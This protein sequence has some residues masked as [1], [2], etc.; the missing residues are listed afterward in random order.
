MIKFRMWGEKKKESPVTITIDVVVGV[1][2][3]EVSALL[4]FLLNTCSQLGSYSACSYAFPF[5]RI[6]LRMLVT[7][8][9]SSA[10]KT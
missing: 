10:E 2:E 8:S 5:G 4:A 7:F 1:R 3:K 6:P 9:T